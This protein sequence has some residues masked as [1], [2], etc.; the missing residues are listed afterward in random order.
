MHFF[1]L[2]RIASRLDAACEQEGCAAQQQFA[3]RAQ[4]GVMEGA[5]PSRL[6]VVK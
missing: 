4:K 6:L 3:S 5:E 1:F 2:G